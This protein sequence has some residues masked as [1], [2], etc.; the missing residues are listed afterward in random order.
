MAAILHLDLK[1]THF[2]VIFGYIK[3]HWT[4]TRLQTKNVVKWEAIILL[5]IYVNFNEKTEVIVF[6]AL[7]DGKHT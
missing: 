2:G 5:T 3:L 4:E 6:A 1:K 7:R